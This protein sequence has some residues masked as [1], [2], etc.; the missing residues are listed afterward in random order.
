VKITIDGVEVEVSDLAA[1]LIGK[2]RKTHADML[3]AVQAEAKAAKADGDKRPARA[4][5]AE[6]QVT[7]LNDEI[8]DAARRR[9]K[10]DAVGPLAARRSGARGAR[11]GSEVRRQER[12]RDPQARDRQ[13]RRA[14]KL[15]ASPPS[16]CAARF[17][18]AIAFA[19]KGNPATSEAAARIS[20]GTKT[21]GTPAPHADAADRAAAYDKAVRN[22]WQSK[23]ESK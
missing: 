16:T 13:A 11:Q 3:S 18:S 20:A 1:Q 21:E 17:D 15:E 6:A 12:R 2:E 8:K 9:S 14:A 7:K 19:V 22:A 5:A 10:A 4:D 23:V